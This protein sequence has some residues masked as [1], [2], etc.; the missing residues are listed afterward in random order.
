[1]PD[2]AQTRYQALHH[3][4]VAS[5]RVV[6]YA[7][8]HYPNFKLGNMICFITSYPYTCKPEDILE[9]QHQMRNMNWYCSSSMPV[10]KIRVQLMDSRKHLNPI[11]AKRAMS[12][13]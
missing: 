10:G 2:S 3:Q 8:E 6:K 5:A 7:H 11:S 1:M 12:S 9:A 13:S 4:F